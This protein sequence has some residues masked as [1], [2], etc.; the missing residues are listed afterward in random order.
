M[1]YKQAPTCETEEELELIHDHDHDQPRLAHRDP[2][3][4]NYWKGATFALVFS[5]LFTI[6]YFSFFL[7]TL[8]VGY[9][10]S[11]ATDFT[12]AAP[13]VHNVKQRFTNALYVDPDG[14]VTA[15]DYRN[16][17]SYAGK[18]SDELDKKWFDLLHHRYFRL[19]EDEVEQLN[20]ENAAD[21]K[22]L[23]R[24]RPL[25][26]TPQ[27]EDIVPQKGVYGGLD[28]MHSL[29]CLDGMR[30]HIDGEPP[31]PDTFFGG[32]RV[33]RLHVDHCVDQLRQ[34]A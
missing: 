26:A 17:T 18:P 8:D 24:S 14:T 34:Y 33:G 28:F 23:M 21:E 25:I 5:H 22:G 27:L 12:S 10:V 2:G 6:A 9:G 13:A 30:R 16:A 3:H 11:H 7:L 19:T 1:A 15:A 31:G 29:H 4:F 32:L 20:G